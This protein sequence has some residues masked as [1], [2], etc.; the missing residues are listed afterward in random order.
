MWKF[1]Q[2]VKSFYEN[3]LSAD[4]QVTSDDI[5]AVKVEK[6]WRFEPVLIGMLVIVANCAY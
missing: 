6:S 1:V 4:D 5:A 2:F 3:K